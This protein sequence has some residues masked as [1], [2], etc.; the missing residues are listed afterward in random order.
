MKSLNLP[1]N[2]IIVNINFSQASH[3]LKLVICTISIC[4]IILFSD[5]Q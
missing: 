2:S 3:H 4:F 5:L 1:S